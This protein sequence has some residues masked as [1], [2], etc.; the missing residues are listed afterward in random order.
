[1]I[2]ASDNDYRT[3]ASEYFPP[4]ETNNYIEAQQ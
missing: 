3:Q 1:M 2:E 4:V